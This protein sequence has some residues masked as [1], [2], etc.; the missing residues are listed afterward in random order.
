MFHTVTPHLFWQQDT[1]T[2]Y[3]VRLGDRCLLI[4]CGT[5]LTPA[6]LQSQGINR[7]EQI[8]LTH[9][10]RDQCAGARQ[11]QS[12]GAQITLPFAERRFFEETDLLKAAYDIYDNY[13]AFQKDV[14]QWFQFAEGGFDRYMAR[15]LRG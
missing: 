12:E 7:V 11:W 10:H 14:V 4:D 8:L 6:A 9:F 13:T 3:G 15:K 5:D 1:C 2:I